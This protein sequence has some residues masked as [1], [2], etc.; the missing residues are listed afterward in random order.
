MNVEALLYNASV[1]LVILG[2]VALGL[3]SWVKARRSAGGN[4]SQ[5]PA[6]VAQAEALRQ[7]NQIKEA[8]NLLLRAERRQP[9]S[10]IIQYRLA[11]YSSLLKDFAQARTHL[12]RACQLDRHWAAPAM[13]DPDL[14]SLRRAVHALQ[15]LES[16]ASPP[17]AGSHV[18]GPR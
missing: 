16:P 4:A 17:P 3:W 12:K 5:N 11:C 8:R 10:S 2:A 18:N 7:N 15:E 9:H 6:C 13:Y 14:H 1:A